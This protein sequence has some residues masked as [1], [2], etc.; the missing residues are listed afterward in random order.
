MQPR[1]SLALESQSPSE[2]IDEMI[3]LLD[4]PDQ[5]VQRRRREVNDTP[6][7]VFLFPG[8]ISFSRRCKSKNR[9]KDRSSLFHPA[10]SLHGGA[11]LFSPFF[12][13]HFGGYYAA[14]I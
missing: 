9:K 5:I 14:H 4:A 12:Q 11:V 1:L 13:S 3:E 2:L 8:R 7:G 6:Q 10:A